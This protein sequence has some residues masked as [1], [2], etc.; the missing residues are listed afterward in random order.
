MI[1]KVIYNYL[2]KCFKDTPVYTQIP[3]KPPKEYIVFIKTASTRTNWINEGT[4]TFQSYSTSLVKAIKLNET[5]KN[6]LDAM[7]D[8]VPEIGSADLNADYNY[9][10]TTRNE[11]RYQAIYNIA[12]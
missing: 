5:L 1:E 4:F 6:Y 10:D 8:S 12:Y 2:K 9:T 11:Y 7:P 3:A